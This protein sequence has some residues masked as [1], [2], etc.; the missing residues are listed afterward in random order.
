MYV[1]TPLVKIARSTKKA[2]SQKQQLHGLHFS[3]Q[4]RE[5]RSPVQL[6][7]STPASVFSPS[8]ASSSEPCSPEYSPGGDT[9][10]AYKRKLQGMVGVMVQNSLKNEEEEKALDFD[11][12]E[13]MLLGSST[14]GPTASPERDAN[15]GRVYNTLG[16]TAFSD[17]RFED[18]LQYYEMAR[19][20]YNNGG[21]SD[22]SQACIT[23]NIDVTMKKILQA[24]VESPAARKRLA[25]AGSQPQE[26]DTAPAS[27]FSPVVSPRQ[28]LLERVAPSGDLSPMLQPTPKRVS[29]DSVADFV[30]ELDA[31][32]AELSQGKM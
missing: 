9:L 11:D 10:S 16:N 21:G 8:I 22:E 20:M 7:I 25:T 4:E 5:G 2:T 26:L 24:A 18:A 3:E 6:V 19:A 1:T 23:R 32:E 14:C 31:F 12:L 28:S 29:P 13:A 15:D 27:A 17:G 30:D